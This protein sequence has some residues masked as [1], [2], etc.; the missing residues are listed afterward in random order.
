[1]CWCSVACSVA[2]GAMPCSHWRS[3]A[4]TPVRVA[5]APSARNTTVMSERRLPPAISTRERA[6]QALA[7][8]MPIPKMAPPSSTPAKEKPGRTICALFRSMMPARCR[9]CEASRATAAARANACRAGASPAASLRSC[10]MRW[11]MPRSRQKRP[12]RAATPNTTP[13]KNEYHSNIWV[14]QTVWMLPLAWQMHKSPAPVRSE[15]CAR[16][17]GA[18]KALS[19]PRYRY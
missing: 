17:Q 5:C 14:P 12:Q 18:W 16:A 1:M 2:V 19:F 10:P 13:K 9:P 3:G 4:S 11:R 6:P 15:A 8:T 7:S